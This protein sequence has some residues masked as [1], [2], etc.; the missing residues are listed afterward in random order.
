M[1]SLGQGAE[2]GLTARFTRAWEHYKGGRLDDAVAGFRSA[3]AADARHARSHYNLAL[4]LEALGRKAEAATAYESF[5]ACANAE[6]RKLEP[7]VRARITALRAPPPPPPSATL[8]LGT[9]PLGGP[10]TLTLGGDPET[11]TLGGAQGTLTLGGDKGTL[12]LGG[13]T[14]AGASSTDS[15]WRPGQVVDDLYE[16]REILGAG[17][18]GSVL[19]VIHRG[20]DLELAVKSLHAEHNESATLRESF[21]QEA[22]TWVGLGLHPHI[23]TCYFVRDLGVPRIFVESL[24]GGTL[25]QWM[26]AG[27]VKDLAA[28]LDIAIQIARAMEYAHRRRLVHRDLKP[29]N[30]LM[31][32][33]GTVKVTDFGLA[34]IAEAPDERLS[35]ADASTGAKMAKVNQ[36]L[37]GR[38]LGT[39]EYMSPEQWSAARE[40]GPAA[41]IWSFGVILYE[42]CCGR[43]PFLMADDE[44]AQSFYGRLLAGGWR[45][46][47][48]NTPSERLNGLIAA[49]LS[50]ESVGRPADFATIGASLEAAYSA[51]A[52]A[53]YP[54]EA[55][56]E[57]PLLAD[58]LL[59]QGVSMADLGRIDEAARLFEGALRLDPTHLGATYNRTLLRAEGWEEQVARLEDAKRANPSDWFPAFLL[60]LAH[61]GRRD[62]ASAKAELA[63]ASRLSPGNAFIARALRRVESGRLSEAAD[64][65]IALPRPAEGLGMEEAAF[66]KLLGRARQDFAVGAHAEAYAALR[67]ARSVQGYEHAEEAVEL[68]RL[69]GRGGKRERLQGGW[70][71]KRYAGSQGAVAVSVSGQG[72]WVLSAHDDSALRLWDARTGRCL[73]EMRGQMGTVHAVCL[74][75][76]GARALSAGA[77]GS[78]ALWDTE[79]GRC[80]QIIAAHSSGARALALT[81]DGSMFVSGGGDQTLRL[82]ETSTGRALGAFQ[83]HQGAVS[84][85]CVLLDGRILTG[86][87]DGFLRLWDPSRTAATWSAAAHTG[88]V[89]ALCAAP[90]GRFA[91]SIGVDGA[92]KL[93]DLATGR[94]A[95]ESPLASRAAGLCLTSDGRALLLAGYDGTLEVRAFPGLEPGPRLG[96]GGAAT[97]AAA[98]SPD[99]GQAFTAGPEGLKAWQ[100]D[101]EFSFPAAADSDDAARP[102]PPAPRLSR[103]ALAAL[104]VGVTWAVGGAVFLRGRTAPRPAAPP[105]PAPSVPE[106]SAPSPVTAPDDGAARGL[107]NVWRGH[108]DSVTCAAFSPDGRRAL[109]GSLDNRIKLWD[110]ASGREL[111]TWS[112]HSDTVWSVAFSP[113]GRTALSGGADKT[114]RLWD[115]ASSRALDSWKGHGAPVRAVA[116]S[117][118]GLRVLSASQ[119]G[120]LILWAVATGEIRARW[121]AHADS[122][123]AVVFAPDG[124]T[125][126]SAGEDGAIKR[127][128]LSSSSPGRDRALGSWLAHDG[129][130]L[131]LAVSAD[132]REAL[133]GGAD[134]TVRLWTAVGERITDWSGHSDAVNSVAF[135]PDGRTAASG[136][137]DGS[138]RIWNTAS[139]RAL[140]SWPAHTQWVL[141]VAYSPNGRNLLSGSWD[142]TLKLW[143]AA[144]AGATP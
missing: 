107:L 99:G 134:K 24:E 84:E 110:A 79:S 128:D 17:S 109:S 58:T 94:C 93:W 111:A 64:Y 63:A 73:R 60:G 30:C 25:S 18:F 10:G 5:L 23:V 142:H 131:A 46:P 106:P 80:L 70:E 137:G 45:Y 47:P 105:Q 49:C 59:N 14:E 144:A 32:P 122:A 130:V 90:D 91:V 52:G 38:W 129:P 56:K 19:K 15:A 57:P 85:A 65:F 2:D 124:R 87:S 114:I 126:L 75:S 62:A 9:P 28:A 6:E 68:W 132:G 121:A 33:G 4:C 125:A 138:V 88:D 42:L 12:T 40:A 103:T 53:A 54:R 98:L 20:W 72:K 41:D 31:T 112:G 50:P 37:R 21:V 92:L 135:S 81:R 108:T 39:P 26:K 82:W 118:D 74:T 3:L 1:A 69:L 61:A 48:P 43:R 139:G 95:K 35:D 11:L 55:V 133:S 71:Q 44:P 27:N 51:A 86:D 141:S 34:K 8:T 100:L 136:S 36:S 83:G 89:A 119:D 16:V 101:W 76:D 116:Y 13:E 104:L 140:K 127:W 78:V 123:N 66:R 102:E 67:K 115:V 143:D 96:T 22:N 7:A 120:A 117:P 113:D 97:A 29:G 77:D